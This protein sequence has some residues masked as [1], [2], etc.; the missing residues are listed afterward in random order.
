MAERS[1]HGWVGFFLVL[2]ALGIAAMVIPI[3]YNL[4]L[5]LTPEQLSLARER[6]RATGPVD[7]VLNYQQRHTHDGVQ[8][9]TAYHVI[10]RDRHIA[11]VVCDGELT[12]LNGAGA[13]LALGLWPN[14]LPGR[15]GAGDM[16]D[17]FDFVEHRLQQDL[18]QSRRP[19]ATASFAPTDGHI[20]RY[21]RRISGGRERLEWT[22]K[23]LQDDEST[24]ETDGDN[25]LAK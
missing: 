2:A 1:K 9:E 4:G 23:L 24:S 11:A 14:A 19:Y 22:V 8:E 3:V 15:S 20:S 10:V 12:Y 21:V 17:L 16:D 6:W 13:R 5:Q 18:D 25:T 7:Y